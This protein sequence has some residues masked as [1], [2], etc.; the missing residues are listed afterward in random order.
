M[1][2]NVILDLGCGWIAILVYEAGRH[3]IWVG[4]LFWIWG[5]VGL[6][7]WFMK[8][9]GMLFGLECYFEFGGG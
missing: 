6:L 3:A 4:M 1:G 5:V 9:D 8:L 2:W 7:F